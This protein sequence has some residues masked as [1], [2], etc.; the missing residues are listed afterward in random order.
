MRRNSIGGNSYEKIIT[1]EFVIV[2]GLVIIAP[3][4]RKK[5]ALS[6]YEGQD[7]V[8]LAAI[9]VAYFILGLIAQGGPGAARIAA[10]F[11]GLLAIGIGL[12]E[13]AELAKVFD[14]FGTGSKTTAAASASSEGSSS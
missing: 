7:L 10:W 4:T 1:A 6:P 3:F 8:Q 12:A 11:G 13:A 9:A 14:I 5:T 2:T